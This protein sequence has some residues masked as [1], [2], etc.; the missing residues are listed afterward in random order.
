[1]YVERDYLAI[2]KAGGV[3]LN[4]V[5]YLVVHHIEVVG[6]KASESLPYLVI[7]PTDERC[8]E[9]VEISLHLRQVFID[10]LSDHVLDL[11]GVVVIHAQ[12]YDGGLPPKPT[13]DDGRAELIAEVGAQVSIWRRDSEKRRRERS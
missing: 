2:R 1:M 8:H 13:R 9:L 11:S 6:P 3:I 5:G 7:W 4:P 12:A 10:G